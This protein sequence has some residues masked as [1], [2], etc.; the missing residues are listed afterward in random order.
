MQTPQKSKRKRRESA[1]IDDFHTPDLFSS[2]EKKLNIS[3]EKRMTKASKKLNRKLFKEK[4]ELGQDMV[5]Q[6]YRVIHAQSGSLGGGG[7][8]GEIYGELT[9]HSFQRIIDFM[10]EHCEL[11]EE[12][13]FLD[14]GSGLGKP[15]FHAAADP[16]VKLSIGVEIQG[17]RWWQSINLL[18]SILKNDKTEVAGSRVFFSHANIMNIKSLDVVT[19]MYIFNCGMPRKVM[20][21]IADLFNRADS[22]KYLICFSPL[23]KLEDVGFKIE[24]LEANLNGKMHGSGESH[25]CYIYIKPG[26]KI[27]GKL[28]AKCK[29]RSSFNWGKIPAP[30][31]GKYAPCVAHSKSYKFGWFAMQQG[32][33]QYR[34]W[35]WDQ[36]GFD[37]V[38]RSL[39]SKT[40]V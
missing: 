7:S 40:G 19:H 6:I 36:I 30:Q 17:S 28:P 34:N 39:R 14:I 12:S 8:G 37:R 11:G 27:G 21:I 29:L 10:K 38:S 16:G 25:K 18:H 32:S 4:A 26:K 33:T 2:N 15:N 20:K 9:K 22:C 5:D 24:P 1:L 31:E 23:V 3:P 35:V 13:V